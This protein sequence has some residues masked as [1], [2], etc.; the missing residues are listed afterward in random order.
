MSS[1]SMMTI[2]DISQFRRENVKFPGWPSDENA[3][4]SVGIIISDDFT[5]I[6]FGFMRPGTVDSG[7]LCYFARVFVRLTVQGWVI[8]LSPQ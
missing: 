4:K 5:G 7:K 2:A 6:Y 8:R 3:P 1:S